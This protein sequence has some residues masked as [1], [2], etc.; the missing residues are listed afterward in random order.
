MNTPTLYKQIDHM[1]LF[2]TIHYL[3][4]VIFTEEQ[5]PTELLKTCQKALEMRQ[6]IIHGK[7]GGSRRPENIDKQD[8]TRYLAAIRRVCTILEG[9]EA[10]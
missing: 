10:E 5:M 3:F 4:P 7:S 1:G 6:T 9:F 2:G 8:V